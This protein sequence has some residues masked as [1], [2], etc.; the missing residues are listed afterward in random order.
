MQK[1]TN[2]KKHIN[3]ETIRHKSKPE[4]MSSNH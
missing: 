2:G 3:Y 4:V 1:Y